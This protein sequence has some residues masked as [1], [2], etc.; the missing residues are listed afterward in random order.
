MFLNL[1]MILFTNIKQ[2]MI[3]K[4]KLIKCSF[5]I[6]IGLIMLDFVAYQAEANDLYFWQVKTPKANIYLLGS[7][8][9]A[10]QSFYPLHQ[11]IENGF[12]NSENL[13]LECNTE[14]IDYSKILNVVSYNDDTELKDHLTK[15]VYD[16]FVQYCNNHDINIDIYKK[17]KP[18]YTSILLMQLEMN[19]AGFKSIYGLDNYFFSKAKTLNKSIL[20]LETPDEQLSYF[21]YFENY[22]DEYILNT[23]QNLD[24]AVI[25]AK[26]L[27]SAYK[28]GE[29]E[30][31]LELINSDEKRYPEIANINAKII[32]ERNQKMFDKI[33]GFIEKGGNYFIIAGAAHLIGNEGIVKK[34]ESKGYKI[35]RVSK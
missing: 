35:K 10:N 4:K 27:L 19:K 24:S 29:D 16:A 8:H 26:I 32:T 3:N 21:T 14:N 28:N 7:I 9:I 2:N 17:I 25:D 23:F 6:L 1:L 18:W 11:E 30:A 20:E 12:S 13:V 33:Q 31:L 15:E 22:S 34:I 5:K